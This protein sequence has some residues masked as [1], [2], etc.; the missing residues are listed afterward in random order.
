MTNQT[1]SKLRIQS[2]LCSLIITLLIPSLT[3]ADDTVT[4][5]EVEARKVIQ[6]WRSHIDGQSELTYKA[7]IQQL[8]EERWSSRAKTI[9]FIK[10]MELPDTQLLNL[11]P[12]IKWAESLN[13]DL[14][15]T[16]GKR[17]SDVKWF[18]VNRLHWLRDLLNTKVKLRQM[19]DSLPNPE[20]AAKAVG[21]IER[22]ERLYDEAYETGLISTVDFEHY[23]NLPVRLKEAL[24]QISNLRPI[25]PPACIAMIAPSAGPPLCVISTNLIYDPVDEDIAD[26]IWNLA[27]LD[28]TPIPAGIDIPMNAQLSFEDG[29]PVGRGKI[30][31]SGT[32]TQRGR[33]DAPA[34]HARLVFHWDVSPD[35]RV[36]LTP[37]GASGP[38]A[39]ITI[40]PNF[41]G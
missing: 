12:H 13:P 7:V 32:K 3:L 26:A 1:H 35:Y 18:L 4:P 29:S 6:T 34:T 25:A 20:A 40:E 33:F 22:I 36:V 2:F 14:R 38:K 16:E 39:T 30:T 15:T 24:G 9:S 27:P 19:R 28:Q 31:Y 8:A 21:E 23:M 37:Q 10:Q 17:M 41:G 11:E 5:A